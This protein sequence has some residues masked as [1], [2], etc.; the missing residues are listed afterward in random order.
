MYRSSESPELCAVSEAEV[1]GASLQNAEDGAQ[2]PGER[3]E[4]VKAGPAQPPTPSIISPG[5][6]RTVTEALTNILVKEAFP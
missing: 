4:E 2:T 5:A 1:A 6:R 3:M